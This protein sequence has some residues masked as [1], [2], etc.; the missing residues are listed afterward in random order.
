M[1]SGVLTLE[2]LPHEGIEKSHAGVV[3]RE[4][5]KDIVEDVPGD[6]VVHHFEDEH[7]GEGE[8]DED[9]VDNSDPSQGNARHLEQPTLQ[10]HER[11]HRSTVGEIISF[12]EKFTSRAH[13]LKV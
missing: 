4:N 6:L 11:Y 1:V 9:G 10:V 7:D 8:H 12:Y 5:D 3:L 13:E 2:P